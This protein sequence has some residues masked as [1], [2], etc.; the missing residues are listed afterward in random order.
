[1]YRNLLFNFLIIN[2]IV[3]SSRSRKTKKQDLSCPLKILCMLKNQSKNRVKMRAI[4][5]IV[6]IIFVFICTNFVIADTSI[7]THQVKI[8]E[9]NVFYNA[10]GKG[11]KVILFLHGLFAN[12]E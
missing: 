6:V 9:H 10:A 3:I 4:K 11:D 8:G 2:I 5:S 12:K 1:M 7:T